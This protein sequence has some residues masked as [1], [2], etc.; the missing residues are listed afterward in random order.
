[1]PGVSI[2]QRLFN[3]LP[4]R[5]RQ[6]RPT[7]RRRRR[8]CQYTEAL[9][10]RQLLTVHAVP[11][12]TFPTIDAALSSSAV[13]DGDV[14]EMAAGV[15]TVNLTVARNISI[16]GAGIGETILQGDPECSFRCCVS[17]A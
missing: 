11:S 16:R 5:L 6:L 3:Q 9:E 7:G 8:Q 14:I 15:Y 4:A 10:S 2:V 13:V 1:M 17:M 12:D